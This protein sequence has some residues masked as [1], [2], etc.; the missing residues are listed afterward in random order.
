MQ[1]SNTFEARLNRYVSAKE[2][3]LMWIYFNFSKVCIE[4]RVQ[5]VN[6]YSKKFEIND[7]AQCQYK[8]LYLG[9]SQSNFCT[10]SCGQSPLLSPFLYWR[11]FNQN[12]KGQGWG[13]CWKI[14]IFIQ[15]LGKCTTL[16]DLLGVSTSQLW[17]LWDQS[18][19]W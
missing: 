13:K 14:Y 19:T 1:T 8:I 9:I 10:L 5:T 3:H 2:K 6:W 16:L 12:C 11:I 15:V 4:W 7:W 17:P 18:K